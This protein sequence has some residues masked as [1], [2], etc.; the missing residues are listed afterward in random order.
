MEV[1]FWMEDVALTLNSSPDAAQGFVAAARLKFGRS[2]RDRTLS[3]WKTLNTA[4]GS[5]AAVRLAYRL[6]LI[7][8]PAESCSQSAASDDA[9]EY[10][11]TRTSM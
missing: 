2:E 7:A 5:R 1:L 10:T 6:L 9:K 4:S 11:K 3:S 8:H